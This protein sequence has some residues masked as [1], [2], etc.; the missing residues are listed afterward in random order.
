M[1]QIEM[2][3]KSDFSVILAS[4]AGWSGVPFR[5]NFYTNAPTRGYEA[6]WDGNEWR[7]CHLTDDG[8]L[9]VA[10]DNHHLGIGIL[11]LEPRFYLDNKCF[12]DGTCMEVVK[13]FAPVFIDPT[14]PE[15]EQEYQLFLGLKGVSSLQVIGTLPPFWQK[16]DPGKPGAPG[17]KGDKG[18]KGDKGGKG[19]KGEKGDTG[20][21][22]FPT[23]RIN[24]AG[25]LIVEIGENEPDPKFD[26]D[27]DGYLC[28]NYPDPNEQ[29]K[30]E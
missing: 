1:R 8:R 7:N 22:V 14:Q 17:A 15:G 11:M 26:I 9:C 5:L 21:V 18:D 13:P 16:G 6:S 3:F 12:N 2:N 20:T 30:A 10:F 29:I 25:E 24:T 28:V 19:D 23:L 4:D 27:K